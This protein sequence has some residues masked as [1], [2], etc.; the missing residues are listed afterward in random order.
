MRLPLTLNIQTGRKLAD[1]YK[2]EIMNEVVKLYGP[3][4]IRAVQICY[5][6]IRVTFLSQDVLKKAKESTGVHI[7]GMWCPI[8][9]G[10]PP[11]TMV[12]LFDYPF[13]ETDE[14][15]AEVFGAYGDVKRVSRSS[16]YTGT[17]LVSLVLKSGYTLP[18]FIYIDGYNCRIWYQG[19]PLI[20]N[21]CAI[22]GHKSANCPNKD[23][24]C[25][26]GASGHFAWA[27]PNP[28][29]VNPLVVSD[30]PAAPA[31]A[32]PEPVAESS[33]GPP[34]DPIGDPSVDLPEG[35]TVPNN[36]EEVAQ[37][38]GSSDALTAA[39][40]GTSGVSSEIENIFAQDLS[41]FSSVVDSYGSQ[42]ILLEVGDKSNNKI[43]EDNIDVCES[44]T[45]ESN[46]GNI[47]LIE[48]ADEIANEIINETHKE[49]ATEINVDMSEAVNEACDEI[50][51]LEGDSGGGIYIGNYSLNANSEESVTCS[52]HTLADD[53]DSMDPDA[54]RPSKRRTRDRSRSKDPL[55]H[56]SAGKVQKASKGKHSKLPSVLPGRPT[57]R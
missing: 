31:E 26:C 1:K 30:P 15:I 48:I 4:E 56:R 32:P 36:A 28:W 42:S 7:F 47:N 20:C 5:D 10:G 38:A 53:E 57:W 11:V 51:L 46:E 35:P 14:K 25:R 2:D 23:K 27:C 39:A 45:V 3:G 8:L 17:R 44:S 40:P 13:E 33:C 24:C 34:V 54:N 55:H 12:N 6:T 29:G 37:G 22:Q 18:R 41:D 52:G 21:L 9:G 43:N 49:V 16:V 19:Q 50:V